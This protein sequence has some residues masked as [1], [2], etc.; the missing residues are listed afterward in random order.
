MSKIPSPHF[1][2]EIWAIAFF[3]FLFDKFWNNIYLTYT[4]FWI[5]GFSLQ[6]FLFHPKDSRTLFEIL[7]FFVKLWLIVSQ[8]ELSRTDFPKFENVAQVCSPS[9]L[10]YVAQVFPK[11]SPSILMEKCDDAIC[12]VLSILFYMIQPI[13]VGFLSL[14]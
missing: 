6:F 7:I 11:C 8:S 5:R 10:N 3:N 9:I 4:K 14:S 2:M 13:S 1:Q 12:P